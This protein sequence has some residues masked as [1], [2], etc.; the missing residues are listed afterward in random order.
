MALPAF[1]HHLPLRQ[2]VS[3]SSIFNQRGQNTEILLKYPLKTR[4]FLN[5]YFIHFGF[6]NMKNI[7]VLIL[8]KDTCGAFH[9]LI[10]N[11]DRTYL[12]LIFN[13]VNTTSMDFEILF[14]F[15]LLIKFSY[16]KTEEWHHIA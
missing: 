9:H 4:Y 14:R 16:I 7:Q 11:A 15:I 8:T 5:Y 10:L 12:I 1:Y 2:D 13:A 3:R 6:V